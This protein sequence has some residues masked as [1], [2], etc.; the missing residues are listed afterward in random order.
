MAAQHALAITEICREI[1][2]ASYYGPNEHW[3]GHRR[4]FPT[5]VALARCNQAF[6]EPA[7]DLL[8]EKIERM[9]ILLALIPSLCQYSRGFFMIDPDSPTDWTRF[10]IYACRIRAI[11]YSHYQSG[12]VNCRIYEEMLHYRPNGAPLLPSLRSV[13]WIHQEGRGITQE[14]LDEI[15]PFLSPS[16]RSLSFGAGSAFLDA[17]DFPNFGDLG[18]PSCDYDVLPSLC[19]D[20]ESLV[21]YYPLPSSSLE[22]LGRL[23]TLRSLEIQ[24]KHLMSQE[25][26]ASLLALP[27]LESLKI[28][29]FF[30]QQFPNQVNAG[31]PSLQTLEVPQSD[32]PSIEKVLN[33]VPPQNIRHLEVTLFDDEWRNFAKFTQSLR[34]HSHSITQL[35]LIGDRYHLLPTRDERNEASLAVIEPLLDLRGLED[36]ELQFGWSGEGPHDDGDGYPFV[37]QHLA[38]RMGVAWPLLRSATLYGSNLKFPLKSLAAFVSHCPHLKDISCYLAVESNLSEV[39]ASTP[40][41]SRSLTSLFVR[42]RRVMDTRELRLALQHLF[43]HCS[44]RTR[45]D[46]RRWP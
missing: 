45:T 35:H 42:V 22:F 18:G 27:A 7:I 24:G 1:C 6:F 11:D 17:H 23:H 30:T 19:P 33:L 40:P 12:Y 28:P 41:S 10:D 38:N 26:H 3:S 32:P 21:L 20:L 34:R 16:V 5:L 4:Q 14:I 44:V 37:S 15:V 43:P 8:W 13:H 25:W 31:F 29:S 9:D 36:L 2:L 46:D 39:V